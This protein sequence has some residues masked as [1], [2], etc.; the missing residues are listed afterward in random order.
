MLYEC[1]CGSTYTSQEGVVLCTSN[2]HGSGKDKYRSSSKN[3]GHELNMG[4]EA[5]CWE[6]GI[7]LLTTFEISTGGTCISMRVVPHICS[8]ADDD[9]NK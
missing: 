9:D 3:F 8:V 6:C 5:F 1:S 2:E 7:P 4:I